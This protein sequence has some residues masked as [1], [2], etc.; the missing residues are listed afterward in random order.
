MEPIV[1]LMKQSFATLT[2]RLRSVRVPLGG[3]ARYS[4]ALTNKSLT[5][6]RANWLRVRLPRDL[7]YEGASTVLQPKR[8]RTSHYLFLVW[9]VNRSV[10]PGRAVTIRF[11]AR[12]TKRGSYR[13]A[14]S[15]R[16][17]LN[18]GLVVAPAAR[19]LQLVA[20]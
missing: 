3:V 5:P 17:R 2:L 14:A 1:S 7:T 9:H 8:R 18:S 12:P 4:L 10:Q 11:S 6:M 20:R 15:G 16:A 13:V 19:P